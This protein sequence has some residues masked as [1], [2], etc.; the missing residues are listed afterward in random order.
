M[1]KRILSMLLIIV[2]V[3]TMIPASSI[4]LKVQ[5]AETPA[6]LVASP[7][8]RIKNGD[9]SDATGAGWS[10]TTIPGK[11]AK[12]E[13]GKANVYGMAGTDNLCELNYEASEIIYQTIDARVGETIRVT[14]QYAGRVNV[15]INEAQLLAVIAIKNGVTVGANEVV[16]L[17]N[18]KTKFAY[19]KSESVEGSTAVISGY[20]VRIEKSGSWNTVT[21]THTFAADE[22]QNG[23]ARV[24]IWGYLPGSTGAGNLID[25]VSV[26]G[27]EQDAVYVHYTKGDDTNYAGTPE[28][29]VKTLREATSRVKDDGTIYLLSDVDTYYAPN[30]NAGLSGSGKTIK[31]VGTTYSNGTNTDTVR[32]L[33][34]ANSDYHRGV[35]RV[36]G[37]KLTLEHVQVDG[38]N[39]KQCIFFE[40]TQGNSVTLGEGSSLVNPGNYEGTTD[41]YYVDGRYSS[42]TNSM[43]YIANT[44]TFEQDGTFY[45]TTVKRANGFGKD[46]L[47]IKA[48][49]VQ[50]KNATIDGGAVYSGFADAGYPT[51]VTSGAVENPAIRVSGG[52]FTLGSNATLQNAAIIQGGRYGAG[53]V[54][55]AGTVNL[56]SGS[57]IEKCLVASRGAAIDATGGTVNINGGKIQKNTVYSS[58]NIV[59]LANNTEFNMTS[60]DIQYNYEAWCLNTVQLAGAAN[61]SGG[62]IRY[63]VGGNKPQN[64]VLITS[65]N[66]NVTISGNVQITDNTTIDKSKSNNVRVKDAAKVTIG[67]N[68][69]GKIG[70]SNLTAL[71]TQFATAASGYNIN[72]AGAFLNDDN[73]TYAAVQSGTGLKWAEGVA[74]NTRTGTIYDTV[75]KAIDNAEAKDTIEILRDLTDN[76][77]SANGTI[78]IRKDLTID[79]KGYQVTSGT[80]NSAAH[81]ISLNGNALDFTL[82]NFT[83]D[84]MSKVE[85]GKY[86]GG[87]IW[88]SNGG[89]TITLDHVNVTNSN[90]HYD[91][92]FLVGGQASNVIL[93]DTVCTGNNTYAFTA[94]TMTVTVCGQT[95]IT[96]NGENSAYKDVY[97]TDA[98]KLTIADDFTG[99]IGVS[100]LVGEGQQFATAAE[101]YTMTNAANFINKGNTELCAVQDGTN[102]R[103]IKMADAEARVRLVNTS[104]QNWVYFEKLEKAV[105]YYNQNRTINNTSLIELLKNVTVET[106]LEFQGQVWLRSDTRTTGN[107]F[108][109]LRGANV[110]LLS[111]AED[112]QYDL[113]TLAIFNLTIDGNGS[114]YDQAPNLIK[115]NGK[116]GRTVFGVMQGAIITN[117][118]NKQTNRY[119]LGT[120]YAGGKTAEVALGTGGKI[121]GNTD[122]Y[123]S[124]VTLYDAGAS[125]YSEGGEIS[126]NTTLARDSEA[127]G[128][129]YMRGG[130]SATIQGGKITNNTVQLA[131][132]KGAA[133]TSAGT[134]TV[135]IKNDV[136][137]TGN[138]NTTDNCDANIYI[139]KPENLVVDK[140][141][142]G[143][144]GI[145][146][147]TEIDQQFAVAGDEYSLATAGTFTNDV[148]KDYCAVQDGTS[149]KWADPV[150]KIQ[151]TGEVFTTVQEAIDK[152]EDGDTVIILR[153][154]VDDELSA[155][156]G[157]SITKDLTLDGADFTLRNG[158]IS[159]IGHIV[160]VYEGVTF[161]LKN[162]QFDSFTMVRGKYRG[163]IVY[164][165]ND[166]NTL[167]LE[168]VNVTNCHFHYTKDSLIYG[169]AATVTLKDVI[170]TDNTYAAFTAGTMNVTLSGYT[171]IQGN[172]TG[173]EYQDVYVTDASKLMIASD[174]TGIIGVSGKVADGE[175]F[176]TAKDGFSVTGAVFKND[177]NTTYHAVQDGTEL[178]WSGYVAVLVTNKV[179]GQKYTT[180]A[181][182]IADYTDEATQ[183]IRML[184]DVTEADITLTKNVYVDL[185]GKT[186]TVNITGGDGAKLYGFD[187]VTNGYTD[188]DKVGKITGT[189]DCAAD[190]TDTT[191]KHTGTK[192]MRYI[193]LNEGGSIEFHRFN[194]NVYSYKGG[195]DAKQG[196][197]NIDIKFFFQG[198][199]TVAKNVK[200]LGLGVS[201]NGTDDFVYGYTDE[202]P[203]GSTGTSDPYFY[204]A[205][206]VNITDKDDSSAY[207]QKYTFKA[208]M[209]I[210]DAELE[211]SAPV[212]SYSYL[213]ILKLSYS[214]FSA[215]KKKDVD[216][217]IKDKGLEDVWNK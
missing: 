210:G 18:D 17:Q 37:Q 92:N 40:N 131:G 119:G 46:M 127:S 145:S 15:T 159:S 13:I 90:F 121:T 25:N 198:D 161:T 213:D 44:Q 217:F 70:I 126:G 65:E 152:A 10:V 74:K 107:H 26:I 35:L 214:K 137:I 187:S 71:D 14:L 120:I 66:S 88:C 182:A 12:V 135:T 167:Y 29:P 80:I 194:L 211:V 115:V 172:G 34:C 202:T 208:M 97:V 57:T 68:F 7:K 1:R 116:N 43:V 201:K 50:F 36:N 55:S 143:K 95:I 151:R 186:V 30:V 160:N 197:G 190:I 52:T 106:T 195:L 28:Y 5:A 175:Q 142:T 138:T 48:G 176:A 170:Y 113:N 101:G 98:S 148:N 179:E 112:S 100:G 53:I 181:D 147:I 132:N 62:N 192:A 45:Y 215:G 73:P 196:A 22:V 108:T 87:V 191:T 19:V 78:T 89:H 42:N 79:G 3:L 155:S 206:L 9:F 204:D 125:F 102:L 8:N 96:G 51:G 64:G 41:K 185:N 193:K 173:S 27:V 111:L 129:I 207:T 21:F 205:S 178:K 16:N 20:G 212:T 110:T 124:A 171:H 183:V 128:A 39:Q 33:Y 203:T 153:D 139:T 130:T 32:R 72:T 216:T 122:L 75:Q 24:G 133:I 56:E 84:Q 67:A 118:V 60:G 105:E 38:G 58:Q 76:D 144:V 59:Y 154:L 164:N 188:V 114:T 123:G 180:L 91:S 93:K 168:N 156:G 158:T 200:K 11:N 169:Q 141:F 47:N 165:A 109:L 177:V 83:I 23:K 149:L 63:N 162:L 136:E 49:T 199:S 85:N 189:V 6:D 140:S 134:G 54:M 117:H 104:Q 209:K 77:F 150:A 157:I 31:I 103:W 4:E 94:G 166:K 163:G 81:M 99:T 82:K 86:R 174:F 184:V 61:L 69:T 2:M 146:G